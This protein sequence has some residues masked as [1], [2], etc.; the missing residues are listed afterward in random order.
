MAAILSRNRR[1]KQTSSV[2]EMEIGVIIGCGI[3]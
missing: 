2:N 1:V 3:H